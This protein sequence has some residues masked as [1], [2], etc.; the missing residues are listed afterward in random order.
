MGRLKGSK[1]TE[2]Q[3]SRIGAGVRLTHARKVK[4]GRAKTAARGASVSKALIPAFIGRDLMIKSAREAIAA[5]ERMLDYL[6]VKRR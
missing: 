4:A 5:V 2:E 3:K 6:G 1:L